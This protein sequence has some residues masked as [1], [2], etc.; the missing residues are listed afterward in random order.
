M[1]YNICMDQLIEAKS[2]PSIM[3]RSRDMFN[4]ATSLDPYEMLEEMKRPPVSRLASSAHG[5]V[6]QSAINETVPPY[7]TAD[8][9]LDAI[10]RL[11][12][13][14][15]FDIIQAHIHKP[16][17]SGGV[18]QAVKFVEHERTAQAIAI[19][20]LRSEDAMTSLI[21]TMSQKEEIDLFKNHKNEHL[22]VGYKLSQTNPEKGCP[23]AGYNGE[24]KINPEFKALVKWIG[25]LAIARRIV[26]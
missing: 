24:V 23:A 21:G 12:I 4:Y 16:Y 5:Y 6:K 22:D 10:L 8:D 11:G 7:D 17:N 19:T 15:T 14:N 25:H 13:T 18:E 3:K 9:Q 2:K 1:F 20:A 26:S